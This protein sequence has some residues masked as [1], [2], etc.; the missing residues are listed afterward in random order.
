VYEKVFFYDKFYDIN[1]SKHLKLIGNLLLKKSELI[2][3][4]ELFV[5]PTTPTL[6]NRTFENS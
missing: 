2:S 1:Q 5:C 6:V 4:L 3:N